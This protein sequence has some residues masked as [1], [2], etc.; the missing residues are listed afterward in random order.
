M[1]AERVPRPN[2]LSMSVA[3][4]TRAPVPWSTTSSSTSMPRLGPIELLKSMRKN[5]PVRLSASRRL[6]GRPASPGYGPYPLVPE[7]ARDGQSTE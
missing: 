7:S 4:L 1:L 5:A 2:S 6:P 3:A